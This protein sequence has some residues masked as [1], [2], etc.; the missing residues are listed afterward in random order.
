MAWIEIHQALFT[1]RKTLKVAELLGLPDVYAAAH[2][3]ALWSWALDNAQD[4]V[5][6]ESSR[7][8]ARAAQWPGNPDEF[9]QALIDSEFV[10]VL[11]GRLIIHDWDSY[12]GR[13]IE[14]RQANA[15]RMRIARAARKPERA[16]NVQRTWDERAGATVPNSTV[17]NSTQPEEGER[18]PAREVQPVEKEFSARKPAHPKNGS[19]TATAPAATMPV[20]FKLTAD[21][22]RVAEELASAKGVKLDVPVTFRKF[23]GHFTRGRGRES[24]EPDWDWRWE[25][26]VIEDLEKAEAQRAEK[27]EQDAPTHRRRDEAGSGELA[28]SGVAEQKPG[29]AG[30]RPVRFST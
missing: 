28:K 24:V 17:Q 14:K 23:V 6:P 18:A 9:V 12:A 2:L 25:R 3:I 29:G 10:D 16:A 11:D 8:V 27:R 7:I 1:H 22:K 13:L 30:L 20:D 4:A 5:L 15:E 21:R 19:S 26:W